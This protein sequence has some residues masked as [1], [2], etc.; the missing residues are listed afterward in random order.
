MRDDL[1][2]PFDL[3]Q[4]PQGLAQDVGLEGELLFV[5]EM[6]VVTAAAAGKIRAAGFDAVAGR[7]AQRAGQGA[8]QLAGFF[9]RKD[10]EHFAGE[11]E[12]D[13]D[14]LALMVAEPVAAV[15]ELFDADG[16]G[17][18]RQRSSAA[19]GGAPAGR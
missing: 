2:A 4:P 3:A 8:D 15:D 7:F 6:L 14:R 18:H 19:G 13:E 10:F 1:A 9:H 5:V 16:E 17:V 12:G 11:H